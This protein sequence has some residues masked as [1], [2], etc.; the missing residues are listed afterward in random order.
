VCLSLMA[1]PVAEDHQ[2]VVLVIPVFLLLT[3]A[4]RMLWPVAGVVALSLVPPEYSWQRFSAGWSM[5]LAYPRLYSV[6]LLW[7]LT[8]STMWKDSHG[9]R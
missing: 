5:L 3:E 7:G 4:P 6:W 2:F 9:R 1:L 8:I